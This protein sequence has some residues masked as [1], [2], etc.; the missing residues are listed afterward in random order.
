MRRVKVR[1]LYMKSSVCE[2]LTPK[3]QHNNSLSLQPVCRGILTSSVQQEPVVPTYHN[4]QCLY[5]F[6]HYKR[7]QVNV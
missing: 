7:F 3:E 2:N 5:V 4:K 6:I 1:G